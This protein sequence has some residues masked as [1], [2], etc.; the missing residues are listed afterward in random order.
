[1]STRSSSS[2][3]SS[4]SSSTSSLFSSS[5][6]SFVPK[7]IDKIASALS[8]KRRKKKK[9]KRKQEGRER[10][11]EKEKEEDGNDNRRSKP[12]VADT[13]VNANNDG[14]NDHYSFV[15]LSE[16]QPGLRCDHTGCPQNEDD[17]GPDP[18]RPLPTDPKDAHQCQPAV[19][20]DGEPDYSSLPLT[21]RWVHKVWKV[22]KQAYEDAAKQFETTPDEHDPTFRPFNQDPSLWKDAVAA[23][24]RP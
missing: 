14:G 13:E 2:S 15:P 24:L 6:S 1:M 5:F 3:S 10:E 16:Y 9:E 12:R 20:A 17:R 11:K 19:M 18:Y 7:L 21:D 23:H 4:P 22:R 8:S